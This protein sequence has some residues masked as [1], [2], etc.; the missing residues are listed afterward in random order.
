[1]ASWH[2]VKEPTRIPVPGDKLIEEFVGRVNTGTE[3]VS[4]AHMK[5]PPGWGEPK[6]TP[7]FGEATIMLSGRMLVEL[8]GE[9]V[10]LGAGEVIWVEP[11]QTVRYSNPYEE[12]NEYWA[13]CVPA[14]HP[15]EANREE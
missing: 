6:Q 14:F 10:E 1:M 3:G 11:G 13:V 9:R 2:H 7:S 12:P 8:D 5:A 15:D 4:I